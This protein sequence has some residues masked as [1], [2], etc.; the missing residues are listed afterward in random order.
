MG[1][2]IEKRFLKSS[3]VWDV[4]WFISNL[5]L[6][7]TFVNREKKIL[8]NCY[9]IANLDMCSKEK[10]ESLYIDLLT[11]LTLN[12]QRHGFGNGTINPFS[13]T[14]LILDQ[15]VE[16]W[17]STIDY[18]FK[19]FIKSYTFIASAVGASFMSTQISC[20]MNWYNGEWG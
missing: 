11:S 20:R 6:F 19:P 7:F 5:D 16:I 8:Y 18:I 14:L 4:I 10:S 13:N 9:T 17:I 15:E 1:W 12:K 2:T 3:L